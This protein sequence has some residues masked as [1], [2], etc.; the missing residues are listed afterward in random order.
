VSLKK[1][2][3]TDVQFTVN[4]SGLAAGAWDTSVVSVKSS[5]WGWSGIKMGSNAIA[6]SQITGTGNPIIHAGLANSGDK[7]QFIVVFNG[8][9]YKDDSGNALVQGITVGTKASGASTYTNATINVA[10]DP[11]DTATN[12]TGAVSGI[13]TGNSYITVP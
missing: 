6:M 12:C 13:G 8:K 2:G 10:C 7:V 3:T 1:F 5:A 4:T 9:E 11:S